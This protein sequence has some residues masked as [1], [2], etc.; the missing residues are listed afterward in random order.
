[1]ERPGFVLVIDLALDG[2]DELRFRNTSPEI[3][4]YIEDNFERIAVSPNPAYQFF[5]ARED[6]RNALCNPYALLTGK[7]IGKAIRAFNRHARKCKG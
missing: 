5:R 1:M 4:R 7:L 6:S 2:R 3:Y